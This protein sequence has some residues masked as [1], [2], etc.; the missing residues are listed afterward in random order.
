MRIGLSSQIGIP[1]AKATPT[2]Q[3]LARAGLL[4]W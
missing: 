3:W 4:V 1:T 2:I